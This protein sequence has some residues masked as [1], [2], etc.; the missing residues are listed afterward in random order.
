VIPWVDEEEESEMGIT[1]KQWNS[2]FVVTTDQIYMTCTQ[3]NQYW[4]KYI[5]Q[6]IPPAPTSTPEPVKIPPK[7]P[8]PEEKKGR[9]MKLRRK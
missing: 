2:W 5:D 1:G 7:V 3:A 6:Y 8:P 4:P 9:M